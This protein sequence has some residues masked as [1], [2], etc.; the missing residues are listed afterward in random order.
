MMNSTHRFL[1][2]SLLLLAALVMAGSRSLPLAQ[3]TSA[4]QSASSILSPKSWYEPIEPFRIIGP[5]NYVGTEGLTVYL[6]TTPAGHI[7]L[8]GTMPVGAPLV[9]ASIRKLGYKPEDIRFLLIS[10][11]HIDHVGSVAHFKRLTRA[12]LTVMDAEVELLKSGGKAD[13][14]FS[15]D[16]A[17]L[18]EGVTADRVLKDGDTIELGGVKLTARHTPGHTRGATTWVTTVK[19]GG[20]SYDVVFPDSTGVNPGTKLAHDPSY[21]QILSDYRRSFRI[22]ESLH[23]DIFLSGHAEFFDMTGKRARAAQEGV[24]AWVDPQGY[25]RKLAADKK[26]FEAALASESKTPR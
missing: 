2:I 17:F 10:H 22:L 19:E 4:Q 14:L 23:P 16:P 12:E 24:K 26:R 25:R 6:I 15:T 18:F 20:R 11:A 8:G 9:E 1:M 5:I 21:P 7:M 13:Y 3:T